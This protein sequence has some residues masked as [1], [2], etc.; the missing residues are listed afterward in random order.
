MK[1]VALWDFTATAGSQMSF[2]KGDEMLL[3]RE[4]TSIAGWGYARL[5]Q[6]RDE[7]YVP[8]T[9]LEVERASLPDPA[10]RAVPETTTPRTATVDKEVQVL[11]AWIQHK[12]PDY[13]V[14]NFSSSWRDGRA[15][16]ALI[17]SLA[18]GTFNLPTQFGLPEENAELALTTAESLFGITASLSA[19]ELCD[20]SFPPERLSL[21]L[22]GFRV[23]QRQLLD[24][25]DARERQLKAKGGV[26]KQLRPKPAI[27]T[28]WCNIIGKT[29]KLHAS[30]G[31]DGVV[32]NRF[33][34]LMG[35]INLEA[36]KV[37]SAAQELI[38][39]ALEE[40][41]Y[42]CRMGDEADGVFCAEVNRGTCC[43]HNR[44]GGTLFEMQSDGACRGQTEVY[45]G[46]ARHTTL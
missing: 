10:G 34:D 9:Y 7:G 8:L 30:I 14:E 12:I 5:K 11:L 20:D 13:Y 15:L 35:Y 18:P 27:D 23:K 17:N 16:L 44:Q 36:E 37:A 21:Y 22:E 1:A 32:L 2:S 3:L 31:L 25:A 6:S 43:V 45:L 4:D 41:L 29:G 19:A 38:G 39:Y 28:V 33:G 26:R 24:E 42:D 46:S 40:S